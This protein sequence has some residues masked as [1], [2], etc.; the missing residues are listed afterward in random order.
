MLT[1]LWLVEISTHL[2][3]APD[4][5]GPSL[6][7]NYIDLLPGDGGETVQLAVHLPALGVQLRIFPHGDGHRKR[8]F[9]SRY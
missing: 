5:F 1:W 2:S 9:S 3:S 8:N 6:T 4:Y 7:P